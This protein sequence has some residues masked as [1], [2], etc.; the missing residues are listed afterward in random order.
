MED[1]KPYQLTAAEWKEIM[2]V[3]EVRDAWG[4]EDDETIEEFSSKVFAA[5]FKFVSG[6]PGYIG[7]LFI[8]QGDVLTGD[9]PMMLIRGDKSKLRRLLMN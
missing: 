1:T 8:L 3:Q 4:I 7:D 9:Q 6:S 2:A 5:K